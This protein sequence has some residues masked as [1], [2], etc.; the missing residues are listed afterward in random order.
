MS[1]AFSLVLTINLYSFA[2]TRNNSVPMSPIRNN[3]PNHDFL[4]HL[5]R[6]SLYDTSCEVPLPQLVLYLL[7]L[8]HHA[9]PLL[10]WERHLSPDFLQ[11][12]HNLRNGIIGIFAICWRNDIKDGYSEMLLN[13]GEK[14]EIPKKALFSR[15]QI[16]MK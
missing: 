2:H 4:S 10:L 1:E 3:F 15:L 13:D 12:A 8:N 7:Y 16:K 11:R 6:R 9:H 5:R 14:N